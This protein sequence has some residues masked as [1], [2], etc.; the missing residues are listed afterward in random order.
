LSLTEVRSFTV[1]RELIDVTEEALREAGDDG[2]ELFVL[3]SGTQRGLI[4]D[5]RHAHVPK[6]TSY[7]TKKGLLVRV[8]GK[9][10]HKLN[11]WLF[12]NSE[13]LAA[14]VHAHPG[15]AYHS[16]TDDTFAI[17]AQLGSLSLVAADFC[18]HGLLDQ[19]SAAYRLSADGWE[20]VETPIARLVQ[21]TD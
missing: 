14:Q 3:W 8:E 6:Q 4:F 13:Q 19:S 17:A 12:E 20:D 15:E 1:R 9:A 11:V 18:A 10:L 7:R 21:V 16:E 5:V 2:Y